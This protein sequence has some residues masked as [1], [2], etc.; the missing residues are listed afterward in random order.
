[1]AHWASVLVD[2]GAGAQPLGYPQ[3]RVALLSLW[4]MAL[5]TVWP[6]Q[7]QVTIRCAHCARFRYVGTLEE[8]HAVHAAHTLQAHG[9]EQPQRRYKLHRKKFRIPIGEN[10]VDENITAART[11]GAARWASDAPQ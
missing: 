6:T 5:V 9:L 10:T 2:A 11:Q 4:E 7:Q 3:P 8:G 1:M